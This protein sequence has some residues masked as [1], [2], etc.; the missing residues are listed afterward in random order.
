MA[1]RIDFTTPW[2]QRTLERKCSFG[3]DDDRRIVTRKSV[4]DERAHF[5]DVEGSFGDKYCVCTSGDAGM[6][7]DPTRVA[8]HD[9]DNEHTVMTL[10]R[11]VQSIDRF[12]GNRHGSVKTERVV[13]GSQ[14]VVDGLRNA[15]D[16]K[17]N[18]GELG[19]HAQSVFTTDD[20]KTFDAEP[21]YCVENAAFTVVISVGIRSAGPEDR[22]SPREDAT[23]GGDI[24]W[25]RV[26]FHGSSPPVPKSE[27][28]ITVDLDTLAYD[29]SDHGVQT[30]AITAPR[31]HS[32]PHRC[33]RTQDRVWEAL[34]SAPSTPLS[35]APSTPTRQPSAAAP[36]RG[37]PRRE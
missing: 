36:S 32:Y 11:G 30:R 13:G 8:S 25:H 4:L 33:E 17:A 7:C 15:H 22:A 35:S 28:L 26:A 6:P 5:I 9:L 1:E 31:Q 21:T 19:R 14:I 12:S 29:S 2:W 34:S 10:R 37:W 16:R 3:N 18:G 23:D 27:E 20:N 24:K